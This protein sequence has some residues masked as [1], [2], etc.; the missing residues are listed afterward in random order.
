MKPVDFILLSKEQI[1]NIHLFKSMRTF[2]W[3]I[4]VLVNETAIVV[5][6]TTK[7]ASQKYLFF[8]SITLPPLSP[9]N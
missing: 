4:Y 6:I 8:V 1:I 7:Y 5:I 2:C 3:V 9:P